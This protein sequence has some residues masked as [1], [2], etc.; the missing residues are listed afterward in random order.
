MK[1]FSEISKNSLVRHWFD[2]LPVGHLF[3]T[4]D[5]AEKVGIH[6]RN[7]SAAIW[8]LT[9]V[10]ACQKVEPFRRYGQIYKKVENSN[11]GDHQTKRQPERTIVRR[12]TNV[13]Y[14]QSFTMDE[15]ARLILVANRALKDQLKAKMD[16]ILT[17][18][19]EIDELLK[20]MK[21]E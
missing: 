12:K 4:T 11:I 13:I 8:Y 18:L 16:E 1:R 7:A 9:Q 17:T 6:I 10:G 2:E 20:D 21:S 15:N 3:T 19:S 5:A 14:P